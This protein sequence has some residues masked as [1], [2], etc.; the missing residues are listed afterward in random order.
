MRAVIGL[1]DGGGRGEHR[2]CGDGAVKPIQQRG[3]ALDRRDQNRVLQGR[4]INAVL[5]TTGAFLCTTGTGTSS[6]SDAD[7]GGADGEKAGTHDRASGDVAHD[8]DQSVRI[9]ARRAQAV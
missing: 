4:T 3:L 2:I 9:A 8:V 7:A 5:F 1:Q 6:D